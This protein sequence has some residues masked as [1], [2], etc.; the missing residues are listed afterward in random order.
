MPQSPEDRF[1][2]LL[3]RSADTGWQPE[4][5]DED[6]DE[7]LPGSRPVPTKLI[8]GIVLALTV[9]GIA[10]FVVYQQMRGH[11]Q[12]P[13]GDVTQVAGAAPGS[14]PGGPSGAATPGAG[15]PA[16]AQATP[17]GD[18]TVHVVGAVHHPKV[19]TLPAG[20]RVTDALAAAGGLTKA[21]SA[22]GLNQARVLVDGEQIVVPKKGEGSTAG[23]GA[24][25]NGAADS[26]GQGAAGQSADGQGQASGGQ[27]TAG[28]RDGSGGA[29]GGNGPGGVGGQGEQ[30]NLNTASA[31]DFE[32]LPGVGPVTAAAIVAHR[33]K[34]GPFGSVDELT[35]VSG[36]GPA[37]MERLRPL[38]TV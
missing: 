35:D 23:G 30:L 19:V 3:G 5:E 29:Q 2:N 34:E 33:D 24:Q 8:I 7:L 25:P 37:T 4:D 38:V 20:S 15:P 13:A 12:D 27:G 9:L 28:S 1:S 6:L 14:Q 21:A 10:A 22:T 32:T 31:Q 17:T 11:Q 18:V 16:G 26:G 36:I